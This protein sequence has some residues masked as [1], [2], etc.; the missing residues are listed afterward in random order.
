MCSDSASRRR[1]RTKKSSHGNFFLSQ[2]QKTEVHAPGFLEFAKQILSK[3]A[4]SA[5]KARR[6]RAFFASL[7]DAAHAK[8]A[9]SPAVFRQEPEQAGQA[10]RSAPHKIPHKSPALP[11]FY[12]SARAVAARPRPP[13]GREGGIPSGFS[14]TGGVSRGDSVP[15]GSRTLSAA[16]PGYT[17]G[18][19]E[20][21]FSPSSCAAIPR[22]A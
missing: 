22:S 20:G 1:T 4:R 21:V 9:L 8:R 5:R 19:Y 6:R 11:D 18:G 15:P 3:R 2:S 13:C 14:G 17:Q 12:T 16:Y 10:H 7:R